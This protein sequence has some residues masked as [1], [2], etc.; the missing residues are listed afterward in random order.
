[1]TR[2]KSSGGSTYESIV[3]NIREG[4]GTRITRVKPGEA[5]EVTTEGSIAFAPDDDPFNCWYVGLDPKPCGE[6]TEIYVAGM[7]FLR[8]K[9]ILE[10]GTAIIEDLDLNYMLTLRRVIICPLEESEGTQPPDGGV[11]S[12]TVPSDPDLQYGAAEQIPDLEAE[13]ELLGVG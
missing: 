8:R 4:M 7:I 13:R 6:Q 1:M 5:V 3:R 11:T 2:A 12:P 10:P 9:F